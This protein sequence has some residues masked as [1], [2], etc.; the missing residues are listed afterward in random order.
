M[1]MQRCLEI[2][3]LDIVI[4]PRRP[5]NFPKLATL[6]EFDSAGPEVENGDIYAMNVR[7]ND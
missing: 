6:I 1:S 3:K 2:F 4:M 7:L 5:D